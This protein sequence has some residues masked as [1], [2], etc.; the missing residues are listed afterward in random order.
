M[1]SEERLYVEQATQHRQQIEDETVLCHKMLSM[2]EMARERRRAA[3]KAGKIGEDI[4]GYDQRLDSIMARDVFAAFVDTP[5]GQKIFES[6]KLEDPLGEGDEVRGMCEKKRCKPHQGW[7]KVLQAGVERR[8][9][10]LASQAAEVAEDERI[11]REAAAERF[12][13]KQAEK[14]WVEVLDG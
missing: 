11:V 4:C 14:N 3:I 12:T 8:V 9:Q 5:E 10:E 2:V 13:R 7:N 6:S 1:S